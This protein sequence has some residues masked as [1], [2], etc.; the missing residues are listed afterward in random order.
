MVFNHS[1]L[2]GKD[3][4]SFTAIEATTKNNLSIYL[5]FRWKTPNV[6][7]TVAMARP[8]TRPRGFATAP[9]PLITLIGHCEDSFLRPYSGWGSW[10]LASLYE[11]TCLLIVK[12]PTVVGA[13]P[14]PRLKAGLEGRLD[15]RKSTRVSVSVFRLT[16]CKGS[17]PTKD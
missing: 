1:A 15:G 12:I 9:L 14:R 8:A 17:P 16:V 10:W 11:P 2:K 6:T 5:H 7:S 4:F 3:L 13:R